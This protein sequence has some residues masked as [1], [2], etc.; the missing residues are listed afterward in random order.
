M[1]NANKFSF[2]LAATLFLLTGLLSS[3]LKE[4]YSDCPRPF[5]LFIKA[6]DADEKDITE[7]GDVQQ[8]ILFVFNEKGE[9]V[10]AVVIDAATVKS[11]KP[12]DIKLEY[13]GHES[14]TFVA[15]GNTSGLDFPDKASVKELNELYAKLKAQNGTA[16]SPPDLFYGNLSVP[17]EYGGEPAA[18]NRCYPTQNGAGYHH[19]HP[20]KTV[21]RGKKEPTVR[22]ARIARHVRPKR[23]SPGARLI[24]NPTPP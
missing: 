3:C 15:W 17:V 11:R 13:P 19:R 6:V 1:S 4:D 2:F 8:V 20:C 5:R 10:D 12:V 21:E 22:V 14:L 24:T 7:S 16:Q 18:T 23:T 9:I